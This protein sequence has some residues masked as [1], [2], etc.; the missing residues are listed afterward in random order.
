MSEVRLVATDL[1]VRYPNT[2]PS[3]QPAL[4]LDHLELRPGRSLALV[5]E[6]G[7]G[8]TTALRTLL[9]LLRPTAG[10]VRWQEREVASLK[11]V[12]LRAFRT[13]VQPIPQDVD[14]ALDPRQTIGSAIAE[15][16]RAGGRK[17]AAP[18]EGQDAVVSRLLDEVGLP[19]SA[20]KRHPHEVSGGQRQRA[21]I[22]RALAVGPEMLLLDE[23]TSGLDATVAVRILEL[24]ERLRADR[25]LGILL[26]SH[27]LGVVT[28][29]CT[30]TIV[31]YRGEVVEHGA[32]RPMMVRPRHPYTATLRRSVPEF[33]VP[34][35]APLR[36]SS[37]AAS[38]DPLTGC[39]FGP[40][41]A[42]ASGAACAAPQQ[43]VQLDAGQVRCARAPDLGPLDPLIDQA[44]PDE[45]A[46]ERAAER[47][48]ASGRSVG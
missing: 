5:G 8:K 9:G 26:I 7:S 18:G 47:H 15:G 20:S 11:G 40:R 33:G 31:L 29:L 41:C 48:G 36:P 2:D 19:S 32:T 35:R 16:W 30:E 6:S 28:W 44:G 10:A 46:P 14:G 21:I 4:Q 34:F 22:A 1:E 27:D 17:G 3:T 13:S 23:P 12:E 39:R 24:I 43:L 45:R 37:S 38:V 42:Y 25:G